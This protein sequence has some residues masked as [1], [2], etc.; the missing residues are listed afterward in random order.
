MARDSARIVAIRILLELLGVLAVTARVKL[1]SARPRSHRTGCCPGEQ[2]TL[3]TCRQVRLRT[4]SPYPRC[5]NTSRLEAARLGSTLRLDAR[6]GTAPQPCGLAVLAKTPMPASSPA[7]TVLATR[8]LR[9]SCAPQGSAKCRQGVMVCRAAGGRERRTDAVRVDARVE[10]SGDA[11][12]DLIAC[13]NQKRRC[14]R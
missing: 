6:T 12:S 10:V 8:N 7:N 1:Q 2:K 11:G 14:V 4:R 3:H 9:A 5:A 13:E